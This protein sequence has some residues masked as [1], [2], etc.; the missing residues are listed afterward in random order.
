M[1]GRR[2]SAAI[3]VA[4]TLGCG[5]LL[6][7]LHD[8]SNVNNEP[9]VP[10]SIA[11]PP[12]SNVTLSPAVP[13]FYDVDRPAPGGPGTII[14]SESVPGGP[15]DVDVSRIIYNSRDNDDREVPVSGLVIV[16]KRPA[17]PR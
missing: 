7:T 2:R 15:D 17:P 4:V 3:A 14:R 6:A 13:Q 1:A 9:A 11:A 8:Q 5:V 16:P 12:D 10:N